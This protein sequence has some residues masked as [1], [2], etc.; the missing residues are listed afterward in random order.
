MDKRTLIKWIIVA[1]VVIVIV[2]CLMA[3]LNKRHRKP[4]PV[5][6]RPVDG[7]RLPRPI[8]YRSSSSDDSSD[9]ADSGTSDSEA[10]DSGIFINPVRKPVDGGRLPR[11]S[12][13]DGGLTSGRED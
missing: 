1:V 4:T 9:I 7:G 13:I 5:I 3:Y 10:S 8:I 12:I 11:P 6:R 2:C